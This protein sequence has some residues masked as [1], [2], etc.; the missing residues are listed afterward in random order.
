MYMYRSSYTCIT[1]IHTRSRD[2]GLGHAFLSIF[3]HVNR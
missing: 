2:L 3:L 1:I